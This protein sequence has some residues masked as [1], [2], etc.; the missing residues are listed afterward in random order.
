MNID[1]KHLF[2]ISQILLLWGII[3]YIYSLYKTGIISDI[4]PRDTFGLLDELNFF[5]YPSI[6]VVTISIIIQIINSRTKDYYFVASLLVLATILWATPTIVE[7]NPRTW[8]A[9]G[10]GFQTYNILQNGEID[11]TGTDYYLSYLQFP[12]SFIFFAVFILV[13]RLD[14]FYFVKVYSF[15]SIP[16]TVLLLYYMYIF[17]TRTISKDMQTI[18]ENIQTARFSALIFILLNSY[19]HLHISP[20]NIGWLLFFVLITLLLSIKKSVMFKLLFYII[21]FAIVIT[22]PTTGILTFLFFSFM[23]ILNKF[24]GKDSIDKYYIIWI[25]FASMFISWLIFMSQKM[26]ENN[27]N[28]ILTITSSIVANESMSASI[29]PIIHSLPQNIRLYTF[30]IGMVITLIYIIKKPNLTFS[31]L[32]LSSISFYFFSQFSNIAF[33]ERT[34]QIGYI[35]ISLTI[36]YMIVNIN[37]L[38]VKF[39]PIIFLI[40][41]STLYV[42]EYRDINPDNLISGYD[43]ILDNF[44]NSFTILQISSQS[45]IY[46]LIDLKNVH[47]LD[48]MKPRMENILKDKRNNSKISFPRVIGLSDKSEGEAIKMG[49]GKEY[50]YIKDYIDNNRTFNKIYETTIMKTYVMSEI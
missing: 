15:F 45:Q 40:S 39:L 37:H 26:T 11:F 22:H 23:T 14:L 47:K 2:L 8:D 25:M 29:I 31:A 7:K 5:F 44:N 34:Y 17:L 9:W 30:A 1:N 49:F 35:I 12:G 3:F 43:F 38:S 48:F 6:I 36:A 21:L 28:N 20:E 42:Y 50:D 18:S 13:S 46:L 32:F 4:P 19:I 16:L 27:I 10:V 41:T 33:I 24:I